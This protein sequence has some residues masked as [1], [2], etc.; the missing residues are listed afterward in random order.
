MAGKG[1][2]GRKPWKAP[3]G[4]PTQKPSQTAKANSVP[5]FPGKKRSPYFEMRMQQ[6]NAH[7]KQRPGYGKTGAY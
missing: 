4:G 6:K 3:D 1:K 7:S 2:P 5:R